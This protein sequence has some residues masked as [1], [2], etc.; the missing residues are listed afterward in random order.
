M[1]DETIAII[2]GSVNFGRDESV[3]MSFSILKKLKSDIFGV[4]KFDRHH[5]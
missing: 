5:L 3:S 4:F 1:V 2:D